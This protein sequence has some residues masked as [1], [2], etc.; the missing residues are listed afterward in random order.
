MDYDVYRLLKKEQKKDGVELR[1]ASQNQFGAAR[2]LAAQAGLTLIR[3]SEVHYQLF[4][5][6]NSWLLNIYPG[7]QRLYCDRNRPKAPFLDVKT[8]WNITDV[9]KAVIATFNTNDFEDQIENTTTNQIQIRAYYLWQAA[10]S[11]IC[12]GKIFWQQAEKEIR[13]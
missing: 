11:P 9:V 8:N 4:L 10:G 5:S 13:D 3:R 2:Q 7:N 12:D 6:K 1:N